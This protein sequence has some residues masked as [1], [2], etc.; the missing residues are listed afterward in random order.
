M[1]RGSDRASISRQ[2]HERRGN[3]EPCTACSQDCGETFVC[4]ACH[5]RKNTCYNLVG[6]FAASERICSSCYNQLHLP[7]HLYERLMRREHKEAHDA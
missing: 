1:R 4:N 7:R 6:G 3:K 2:D 5:L